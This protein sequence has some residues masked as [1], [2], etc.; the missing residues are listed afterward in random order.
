[1]YGP[2]QLG[3]YVL[4]ITCTQ[5]ATILAMFG[6]NNGVVRYVARYQAQQD[7]PRLRGT[8]LLALCVTLG[9]SLALS[10]LTFFGASFLADV[11]ADEAFD[12]QFLETVF[13]AFSVSIPF[14]T[15]MSIALNA[16]QGFQTVKY[17]TYV[18]QI[19]QPLMHLG[20]VVIF[21]LL[22]A[23]VLGAV[24]AYILSMAVGLVF[25]LHYLKRVF[26]EL[27][28]RDIPPRFEGRTL[29]GA[30]GPTV[31]ITFAPNLEAWIMVAVLGIF[32]TAG[33][34]AIY[35]A[36]ARTAGLSTLAVFAFREIFS[37]MI[38]SLYGRGLL[39]DLGR[40]YKDISRWSFIGGLAVFLL[41]VP[42]AKDVMAVFGDEFISGWPVLVV[43]AGAQL[44]NCSVGVDDRVLVMT[45]RHQIVVLAILGAAVT[46]LVGGVVLVPLLGPLGAA[47][48]TAGNIIVTHAIILAAL[49][50]ALGFWPYSYQHL[51]PLIAGLLIGVTTVLVRAVLPLPEGL[52]AIIILGPCVLAG[53]GVIIVALG[54]NPSDQQLLKAFWV[55][56][57]TA[58]RR[59]A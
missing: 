32:S 19:V 30:S 9:L 48:A 54:L 24:I 39:D 55:A 37:P 38:S 8:I 14:F 25:A 21:Y 42:L 18:A 13:K 35:N 56:V 29:L 31:V 23:Q 26:P 1:M 40:L 12:K 57:R 59:G 33:T 49:R 3:F 6:M 46:A 36:A 20:F 22:G 4:G 43:I 27:T 10:G 15:V 47:A 2:T 7:I 58:I 44:F 28:S 52:P 45:G 5:I 11:F 53:F 16:T 17:L 41:T 50:R 34:V 51:K